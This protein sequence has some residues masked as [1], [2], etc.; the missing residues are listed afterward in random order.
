[1]RGAL[2]TCRTRYPA[3]IVTLYIRILTICSGYHTYGTGIFGHFCIT[4][5]ILHDFSAFCDTLISIWINDLTMSISMSKP[6]QVANHILGQQT[7][8]PLLSSPMRRRTPIKKK[9]QKRIRVPE[10]VTESSSTIFLPD[11]L[12]QVK[13]IAWR[14]LSDDE[15]AANF[16][17]DKDLFQKWKKHYPS[18]REAITKGRTHADMKVV[19]S[20]YKRAT[21]YD[22][23]EEGLTRDGD[24]VTL[25]R[26]AIPDIPGIKYWLNNRDKENWS[27]RHSIDG[28]GTRGGGTKPVG[29][30]VKSK[31]DLIMSILDK[32]EPQNDNEKKQKK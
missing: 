16:G 12:A 17:V 23:T 27:E 10:G 13:A 15:I 6:V 22:Y 26:H 24:V 8:R 18:F 32:I 30:E 5:L 2:W 14:G 3:H 19:E 9:R 31:A 4:G 20:L 29:V 7:A 28:G 1:M 11:H 21:G 25:K